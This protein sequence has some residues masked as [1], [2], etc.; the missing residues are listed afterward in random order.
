MLLLSHD[1][2]TTAAGVLLILQLVKKKQKQ[3]S[4]QCTLGDDFAAAGV[5]FV[6]RHLTGLQK[7][8]VPLAFVHWV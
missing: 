3:Q 7:G 2:V 8:S 5:F 6:Y 1:A 4:E